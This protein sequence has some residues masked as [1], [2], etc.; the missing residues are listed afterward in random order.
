MDMTALVLTRQSLHGVAE[1]VLAGPQYR[2]SGTIRLR[3]VPGGSFATTKHPD[4]AV[5]GDLL[6]TSG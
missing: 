6:L 3:A 4:V 1:L 2:Q 5:N